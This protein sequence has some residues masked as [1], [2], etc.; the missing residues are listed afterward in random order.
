MRFLVE[1]C[2]DM[3]LLVMFCACCIMLPVQRGF[4]DVPC[5]YCIML[6]V[7]RG[8]CDVPCVCCI[9]LFVQRGVL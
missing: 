1:Y 4:C 6:P 5:V 9:M 2:S 3:M 8:F 7:Q